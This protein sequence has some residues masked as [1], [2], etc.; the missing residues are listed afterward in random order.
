[1]EVEFPAKPVDY[2]IVSYE[3]VRCEVRAFKFVSVKSTIRRELFHLELQRKK[4]AKVA[5][6][7]QQMAQIRANNPGIEVDEDAFLSTKNIASLVSDLFIYALF[8][9]IQWILKM[10][11]YILKYMYPKCQ[12]ACCSQI[13]RFRIPSGYRWQD[14]TLD[15]CTSTQFQHPEQITIGLAKARWYMTRMIQRYA[16][17]CSSKLF[18]IQTTITKFE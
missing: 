2:T 1:M 14:L 16:A 7:M 11:H 8:Y 6:K 13:T 9:F 5:A 4:S 18:S 17:T 3:L 12:T 10:I 15:I